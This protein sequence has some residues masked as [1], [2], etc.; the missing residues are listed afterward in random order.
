[1]S[2]VLNSGHAMPLIGLG[3]WRAPNE[4]IER[5]V[6]SAFEIGYRH[7]DTATAYLNEAAIGNVFAKWLKEGKVTREELFVCTK[8]P[9]IANRPNDVERYLRN[10]LRDLQ[11]DF[12]DL[13]LVHTPFAVPETNGPFLTNEQ[14]EVIV[15]E[16]SS[17]LD[18]WRKMEEMVDLGLT[19]SIGVS[20]FNQSQIQRILDN[21]RIPPAVLQ[22]EVHLYLQQQELVEFCQNN[23][24]TVTAYSPLGSKGI[25]ELYKALLG[26]ERSLPDLLANPEVLKIAEKV[27]KTPAQVLLRNLLQRDISIIPKSTNADRLKENFSVTDFELSDEDMETLQSLDKNF[28]ICDFSFFKG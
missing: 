12:V 17:L 19:R 25:G 3:S 6:N 2:K 14:G 20:N 5:A 27:G 15:D 9:P 18:V 4:E 26:E 10:S 28:R 7:I 13:Y 8:L 22:V 16:E 11:L 1:M 24:I 23:G 21:C